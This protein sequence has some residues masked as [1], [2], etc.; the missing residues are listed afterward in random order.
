MTE[1]KK[2]P[3]KN[4][5]QKI[6]VDLIIARGCMPVKKREIVL[7]LDHETKQM[8]CRLLDEHIEALREKAEGQKTFC[9]LLIAF[10]IERTNDILDQIQVGGEKPFHPCHRFP[11]LLNR[12]GEAMKRT[13]ETLYLSRVVCKDCG[14]VIK[15]NHCQISK[16]RK[17]EK[18]V[19]ADCNLEEKGVIKYHR[20]NTIDDPGQKRKFLS[21]TPYK[22]AEVPLIAFGTVTVSKFCKKPN[23][24]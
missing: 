6:V 8:V 24:E 12:E 4:Q 14:N 2:E 5:L 7:K 22:Q 21:N 11:D 18:H 15:H 19:C 23:S 3:D 9:R 13:F 16:P 10:Q 17:G 20:T 1:S